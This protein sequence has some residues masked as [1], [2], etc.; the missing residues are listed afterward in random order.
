MNLIEC[1]NKAKDGQKI[2][3]VGTSLKKTSMDNYSLTRAVYN[4]MSDYELLAD[5]WKIVK[6]KKKATVYGMLSKHAGCDHLALSNY[7]YADDL[8]L[9]KTNT[10]ITLEWEE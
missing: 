10:K 3:R 2:E 9:N 5:D 8:P 4:L 7:T 1:W 6:V